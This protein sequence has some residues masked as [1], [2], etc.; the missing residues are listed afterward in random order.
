MDNLQVKVIGER[1]HIAYTSPFDAGGSFYKD[2]DVIKYREKLR[3]FK[4]NN[5]SEISEN[6]ARL[7]F[8]YNGKDV[9]VILSRNGNETHIV[10]KTLSD[11]FFV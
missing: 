5:I 1:V 6:N 4:E 10:E 9:S 8:C 7:I 3:E 2:F 11:K